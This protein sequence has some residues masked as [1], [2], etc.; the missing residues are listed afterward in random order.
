MESQTSVL[1]FEGALSL[2]KS[3]KKAGRRGWKNI[4]FIF[5]VPGSVFTVNRAP[6]NQFY[7]EGTQIKY[8]SH[9]DVVGT[10]DSVGVWTPTN[11]DV[12]SEDWYE[13]IV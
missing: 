5:L 10:D 11:F 1:T 2:I 7:A 12:L 4:K 13:V 8:N 6:L 9:I 3:G